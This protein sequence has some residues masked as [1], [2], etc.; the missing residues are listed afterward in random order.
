MDEASQLRPEDALGAVARGSQLVV[1]GDP[2]QLPPTSFFQRTLDDDEEDEERVA[3][4]EGESIL[5]IALGQ[6]QPVRRLRWHYRSQHHS[7]IAFSNEEF[8]GGD[9]VVFPSAYH[10]HDSLGVKHVIANGVYENRRNP[11]E[12]E[13]VVKAVLEH[14][15]IHPEDS[16]GVVTMNFEQRELIEEL[17]DA[18]LQKDSFSAAWIEH[19]ETTP[20]PFFIKNLENVQGDERDA[21]FISVTYGRDPKGNIFQRFAGVN[22]ASG[23]RRLNVLI[24]RAKKR[25]VV[26]SSLDP[27]LIQ[28]TASSAWGVRALKSYLNYA[29]KGIS[30]SPEISPGAEPSNEHE[31]AIGSILKEH[32]YDVIPQ[33]GVSGY[34]IDLAVRHPRKPGAFLV[35]IEF[36]GKSYHSGRSAR[37]RD[38]LRQMTLMNQG[39]AIHRIWSTDWFKNRNSEIDRLLRRVRSL[40]SIE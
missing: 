23:H 29:K 27:D 10:Q 11:L 37:D 34:F 13:E 20:E 35:G 1:V 16:L 30:A 17:L 31:A 26:F 40:E 25:T 9:L 21:I 5:D 12:A 36:D 14:I 32:G 24:T 18:R 38:R 3:A 7:L 8:Y 19:R 28:T 39:W 2:K 33:V 22:T 4:S 6:Y 15:A